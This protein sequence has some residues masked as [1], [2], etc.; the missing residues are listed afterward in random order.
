MKML[1][2]P[3]LR[4]TYDYDCGAKAL[5]AVLGYYGTDINEDKII[6][7]AGTTKSGTSIKGIIKTLKKFGLKY[8]TY[9]MDVKTIK[10]YIDKK[11][12]VLLDVQA[13]P[14]RKNTN[15]KKSWNDG[16]YVVAIGYDR[17][18][19]FFEDPS[20]IFRTYLNLKE[21]ESRWHGMDSKI[22]YTHLGIAVYGKKNKYSFVKKIHM[23]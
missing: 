4:Q 17:K 18:K 12:P 20:S 14:Q 19:I 15:L 21:F 5:Q 2:F 22:K 16:H 7:I 6:K 3:E 11:I 10:K 23:D 13:W 8:D 9:S 1:E